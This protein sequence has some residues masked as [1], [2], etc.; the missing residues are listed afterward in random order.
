MVLGVPVYSSYGAK[1]LD[2]YTLLDEAGVK[3]L[4]ANGVREILLDDWRVA[5]VPVLPLFSPEV[6]GET[7]IALR[8][9]I[10]KSRRLSRIADRYF[11]QVVTAINA[12]V[13]ELALETI[14]ETTVA[15]IVSHEDYTYVQPAKV[16]GLSLLM[17]KRLGYSTP[18]LANLGLAALL[19]DI[20]FIS[21]PAELSDK[22]GFLT[23]DEFRSIR[24]HPAHGYELL[25]QHHACEDEVATVVLQ[26]HERWNGTGYLQGL[27]GNDITRFA[28]IIAI[29]DTYCAMLSERSQ[30]KAFL[31]HKAMEYIISYRGHQFNPKLVELFI[32][33]VPLYPSGL[34][35]K[36]NTG[37]VGI[38]SSPNLGG[39][40]GRPV[41]RICYDENLKAVE[42]P[43]DMD[44]SNGN[45]QDKAIAQV[46][47]YD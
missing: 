7:A 4:H 6:E 18:D 12:M 29:T 17:G 31:P 45:H 47:G 30:R 1:L 43:Y 13:R 32:R 26:H 11:E 28:Q 19:K 23:E 25:S 21:L 36:L 35:V 3:V 10:V 9:L 34:A 20:G 40:V 41:V 24:G 42:K 8:Q 33:Q 15:G 39:C 38:V 5:D 27:I 14:G 22:A 2:A 44:L 16:A 46:M 37:E